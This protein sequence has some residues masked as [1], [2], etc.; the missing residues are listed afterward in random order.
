MTPVRLIDDVLLAQVSA[1]AASSPR[2]RKNFN[3]HGDNADPAHRLL[4][5]IEPGSYIVPHRHLDAAKDETILVLRGVL[6]LVIFDDDGAVVQAA[7]LSATGTVCGVD[8][9]HG[10]YHTVFACAPG[11]VMFESKGGPFMP[12]VLEERA[13]W[14][15]AEGGE[16]T[17]EYLHALMARVDG[18]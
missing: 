4:N 17:A 7:R 3:F 12:L 5:A 11:T 15:P 14:A 8:I 16:G 18:R 2:G 9:P 1:E 10:V 13:P 6:G